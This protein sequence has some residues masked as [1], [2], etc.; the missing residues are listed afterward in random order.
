M[1]EIFHLADGVKRFFCMALLAILTE[2]IV[3]NILV[4]TG[5]VFKSYTLEFLKFLSV[6]G[7]NFMTFK[8]FHLLMLA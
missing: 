1:I 5:T 8:A 2:L 4:A 7:F 3:M 6:Q